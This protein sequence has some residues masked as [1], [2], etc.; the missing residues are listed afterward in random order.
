MESAPKTRAAVRLLLIA[1][2]AIVTLT[3]LLETASVWTTAQATRAAAEPLSQPVAWTPPAVVES[4][5]PFSMPAYELPVDDAPTPIGPSLFATTMPSAV[6]SPT[7]ANVGSHD[8]VAIDPEPPASAM[9][10]ETTAEQPP[11][12][13]PPAAERAEAPPTVLPPKAVSL[14]APPVVTRDDGYAAYTASVAT[15]DERLKAEVQKGFQLG[16]A[17]ALFAARAKFIGV[18]RQIAVAK[19]ADAATNRHTTA[20]AD[21]L[22]ALDEAD[23]FVP[24]GDALEAELDTQSIAE[25][26]VTPVVREGARVASPSD[27]VARY[28][29]WA[30]QRLGGAVAGSQAGS[31]ACYGLGKAYARL[32]SQADDPHAGRKSGVMHRAALVA[33]PANYMAANELGVRLASLGRYEQ[34]RDALRHAIAYQAPISTIHANLAAVEQKLGNPGSAAAAEQQAT[35]IAQNE[36]ATGELSRRNGVEW[37]SP[38]TLQGL[39]ATAKPPKSERPAAELAAAAPPAS[40][41]PAPHRGAWKTAFNRFT[42]AT[43]WSDPVTPTSAAP[44]PVAF[45]SPTPRTAA[46]PQRALR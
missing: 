2:G 29:E 33:H 7:E 32:E 12:A 19:D 5:P 14:P 40:A 13:T 31:M 3:L 28:S 34:A 36:I 38:R 11:N 17:G 26:H 39:G 15:L 37:V 16:K 42:R 24:R 46:A 22:R 45:A 20:L 25:S 10:A 35:V 18:M 41:A 44:R 1:G 21:G 4:P 23:D 27:A 43:G 6:E 9:P 30:A 8:E